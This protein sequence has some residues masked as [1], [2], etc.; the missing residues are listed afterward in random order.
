MNIIKALFKKDI[1]C[2]EEKLLINPSKVR[3]RSNRPSTIFFTTWK[4]GSVITDKIVSVISEFQQ[5]QRIDFQTY[6]ENNTS[7]PIAKLQEIK[8]LSTCFQQSGFF[9]G[10]FKFFINIPDLRNYKVIVQLREPKDVLTSM[11]FSFAF[12]HPEILEDTKNKKQEFLN[13]D[14]NAI[15][16]KYAPD[17]LAHSYVP[18]MKLLKSNNQ[19]LFVTYEEMVTNFD[20]WIKKICEYMGLELSNSQRDRI[21]AM[22]DFKVDKENI[23]SH[24]RSV[25][26]GNYKKHLSQATIDELNELFKTPNEYFGY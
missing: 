21:Y 12:S 22:A 11:Y 3:I 8:F 18:Y 2:I 17:F 13:S 26:P 9:Y 6:F 25:L 15:A 7:D 5:L 23:H 20:V 1:R 4:C 19:F 14:I 16:L 24:K 10:P